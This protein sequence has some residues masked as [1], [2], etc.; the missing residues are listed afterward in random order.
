MPDE[1]KTMVQEEPVPRAPL[2]HAI[3]AM[4]SLN[5]GNHDVDISKP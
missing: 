1:P 2:S 4:L 3:C 5:D